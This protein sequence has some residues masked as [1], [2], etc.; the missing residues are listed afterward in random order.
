METNSAESWSVTKKIKKEKHHHLRML[1]IDMDTIP[2][3]DTANHSRD[4][5]A[6]FISPVTLLVNV[7]NLP[8]LLR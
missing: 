7:S 4:I 6:S 5:M 3:V 8:S 2:K 1:I